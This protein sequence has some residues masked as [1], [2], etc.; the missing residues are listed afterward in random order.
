ML[1]TE[2]GFCMPVGD[3]EVSRN[4]VK[5]HME[6]PVCKVLYLTWLNDLIENQDAPVPFES[7]VL[8]CDFTT[9]YSI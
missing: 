6:I 2:I 5:F 8:T 1:G 9:M 4:P 3:F 7:G